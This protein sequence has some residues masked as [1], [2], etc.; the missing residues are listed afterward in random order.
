MTKS[1]RMWM[2]EKERRRRERIRRAKRCRNCTLT[3][4]VLAVIAVMVIVVNS[5]KNKPDDRE[6]NIAS[7]TPAVASDSVYKSA[8]VYTTSIRE[9][10]INTLFFSNSA[11]AGNSV[12]DSISMY[13]L[14]PQTDFYTGVNVDLENVYTVTSSSSTA[15]IADQFK[16][17]NFKKIFLSFGEKEMQSM[18]SG[19]FKTQYSDFVQKIKKYQ[20]KAQIYLIGITPVTTYVSEQGEITLS[21]IKEFNKRIKSIAVSEE[22]YYVDSVDALGDNKN[23]LPD[24]VSYDGIN[25]NKA[26]VMDLLY[27]TVNESY[28]PTDADMVDGD[29]EEEDGGETDSGAE[30]TDTANDTTTDKPTEKPTEKSTEKPSSQ[31]G[32]KNSGGNE[33]PTPT[34]NVLKDSVTSKK[35]K[36]EG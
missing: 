22:V 17:K 30:T 29:D 25:L 21:K 24:G 34:V 16:S 35:S 7:P 4:I 23:F 20:P 18:S 19:E 36:G 28:V 15:S 2:R 9:S 11:F 6:V 1:Q 33:T 10:D 27:Y 14:L 3:V 32:S 8:N 12:A 13:G 31:G 5:N 26:A